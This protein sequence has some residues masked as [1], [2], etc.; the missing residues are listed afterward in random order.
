MNWEKIFGFVDA[1]TKLW[2]W[3][4]HLDRMKEISSFKVQTKWSKWEIMWAFVS[5][6]VCLSVCMCACYVSGCIL[7]WRW[8][9]MMMC[10]RTVC[11]INVFCLF[12]GW[13][14]PYNPIWHSCRFFCFIFRFGFVVFIM[15]IP[16]SQWIINLPFELL[17][18]ANYN[19]FF[20]FIIS[21]H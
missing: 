1:N 19:Y 20:F 13:C 14:W 10:S 15:S 21:F 8:W 11:S 2:P 9:W 12:V 18:I 4:Y 3:R 16:L 17:F 5:V 6:C 7:T